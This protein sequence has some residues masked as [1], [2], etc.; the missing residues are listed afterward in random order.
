MTI[1]V[2]GGMPGKFKLFIVS[3]RIRNRK[4]VLV[5]GIGRWSAARSVQPIVMASGL[6]FACDLAPLVLC[7]L[8]IN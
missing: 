3:I 4:P 6:R 7:N 2:L 5:V 1:Y 8:S